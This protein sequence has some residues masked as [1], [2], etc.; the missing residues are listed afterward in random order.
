MD[1]LI[2]GLAA[3]ALAG[4]SVFLWNKN[5]Q[6]EEDYKEEVEKGKISI[7]ATMLSETTEFTFMKVT[8]QFVYYM[9]KTG[10]DIGHGAKKLAKWKALYKW[11]YPFH[12]GFKVKEGWNWCI[13]VNEQREKKPDRKSTRLNSSHEFVSRM[14]S[15]A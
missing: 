10:E 13:K 14:P 2:L 11:E 8:N 5:S 7:S 4:V 12:F 6:L 3:I 15:S 1:R 9:D